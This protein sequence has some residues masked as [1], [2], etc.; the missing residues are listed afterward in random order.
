MAK[1][2]ARTTVS[3]ERSKAELESILR[4]YGADQIMTGWSQDG[5]VFLAFRLKGRAI[6]F[7]HQLPQ[8]RKFGSE[9]QYQQAVRQRWRAMVL[10]V[11]SQ[12]EW[13]EIG[14]VPIEE[15]FLSQLVL[16]GGRTV[17]EESLPTIRKAFETGTMP[18]LLP[19]LG[20]D[21]GK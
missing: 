15:V 6:K 19:F 8:R 13:I 3:P 2:A 18:K 14:E 5:L 12:L 7:T 4:R 20:S 16:P 21:V 17:A 1:Y 11:R 10:W 9:S